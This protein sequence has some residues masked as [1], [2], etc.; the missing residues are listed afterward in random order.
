[1]NQKEENRAWALSLTG[2]SLSEARQ[3]GMKGR[4]RTIKKVEGIK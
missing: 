1:M 2:F 3:R 4:E